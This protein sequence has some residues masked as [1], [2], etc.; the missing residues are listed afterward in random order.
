[1][2]FRSIL[3][4]GFLFSGSLILSNTAYIY[5]SV[6]YIQMLKVTGV[7]SLVT[8]LTEPWTGLHTRRDLTYIVDLPHPGTK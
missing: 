6:A 1:M 5:L 2:F 7:F 3:P 4:I 8:S